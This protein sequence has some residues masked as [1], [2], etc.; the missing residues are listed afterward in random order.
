MSQAYG[1]TPLRIVSPDD[2]LYQ[3]VK[4]LADAGLLDPQDKNV[5]DRGYMV[6]RLELALYTEK[7]ENRLDNNT[8]VPPAAP[9]VST[10]VVSSPAAP[11]PSS[12]APDAT[13]PGVP[14]IPEM[15]V[16]QAQASPAAAAPA[17]PAPAPPPAA[18]A[19]ANPAPAPQPAVAPAVSPSATAPVVNPPAPSISAALAVS[20][21]VEENPADLS[22]APEAPSPTLKTEAAP[23][24]VSAGGTPV[25]VY[26]GPYLATNLSP[27]PSQADRGPS[28]GPAPGVGI[29]T[30]PLESG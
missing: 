13:L 17:S 23:E 22:L 18:P 28:Q 26:S 15:E 6:T 24:T 25:S 4:Q 9:A 29:F 16:P 14:A 21:S 1:R 10:P 11:V 12:P 7:A 27:G 19:P 30:D 8:P 20:A 2:P 5:L 3:G